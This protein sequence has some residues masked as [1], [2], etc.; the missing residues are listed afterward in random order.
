MKKNNKFNKIIILSLIVLMFT[1]C[2]VIFILNYTKDSS[3]LSIIEKNWINGHTSNVIDVSVYNDVPIYG[4][5]GEGLIFSYL[6]KFSDTY[7]VKFN[8]ISYLNSGTTNLRDV[9]FKVMNY[10]AVD[11][12]SIEMYKDYYVIVGLESDMIND[13]SDLEGS[14][15]GVFDTDLMNIKYYLNDGKNIKIVALSSIDEMLTTLEKKEVDYIA[16]PENL[17]LDKILEN[18]LNVVYHISELYKKYVLTVNNDNTFK[19]IMTKFNE[20]YKNEYLVENNK[21]VF[22]DSFFKY[23][24]ISDVESRDY[25]NTKYVFGYVGIMPFENTVNK[26]LFKRI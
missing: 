24:E 13:I 23:K 15:L 19:S 5:D 10:D 9:A 6:E 21:K 2:L 14:T 4:K 18:D 11:N 16:I 22:L 12:N 1:I 3:S 7:G 26:E 25:Y 20:I 8:K 17:Y